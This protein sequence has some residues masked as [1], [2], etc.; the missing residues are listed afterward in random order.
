M[1]ISKYI[2][3]F[4][5]AGSMLGVSTSCEDMLDKGNEFVVYSD[6]AYLRNPAD[7]VTSLLGILGKLQGIAERTNLLGEVRADLVVVNENA[8]IDLKNLA[9]NN[10]DINSDEET[11]LYNDPRDYYA[12]I[13]N[14][15]FYLSHVDSLAHNISNK[16]Y[17]ENEIAQV[18]SIRA[19]TYLQA[20]LVYGKVPFVTEPVTTK[21]QS[22]AEYP[23]YDLAAICEY[24]IN[25]LKNLANVSYPDFNN[26]GT[27]SIDPKAMFYPVNVVLGDLYLYMAV[28]THDKEAAKQAALSYY[29]YITWRY[30]GKTNLYTSNARSYWPGSKW[31]DIKRFNNPTQSTAPYYIPQRGRWGSNGVTQIT[32]IAMD[33]AAAEGHFNH[34]RQLYNTT[35]DTEFSEA[36]ISPS[37]ILKELSESQEYVVRLSDLGVTKLTRDM[38]DDSSLESNYFGDLRY[39]TAMTAMKTNMNNEIKSIQFIYKHTSQHIS[40]YRAHQIYLRMAEALNYA[41]YPRMAREILT[42]GLN[43]QVIEFFVLPYYTNEADKNFIKQFDFPNDEFRTVVQTFEW[44]SRDPYYVDLYP[45]ITL[46]RSTDINTLGLHSRGSGDT[47]VN[48]NYCVLSLTD[49]EEASRPKVEDIGKMPTLSDYTWPEEPVRPEEAVKPSTWDVKPGVSVTEAEYKEINTGKPWYKGKATILN[50]FYRDYVKNDSVGSY[51]RALE[52]MAQYEIDIVNYEKEYQ[53]VMAQF[54]ADLNAYQD[55]VDAYKNTLGSWKETTYGNPAHIEREMEVVDAAILN[56]QALE[57]VYEGNRFYDL[58]R[59]ALWYGDN[60]RLADPV[61]KRDAQAGARLR[62]RS[63]WYLHWKNGKSQIGY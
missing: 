47:Y 50:G 37:P 63:G 56:E 32:A 36:S 8:T 62:S 14:C 23:L 15:N 20:V 11:N 51:T 25:D 5:L 42:N 13:N 49:E 52:A 39:S 40:V 27:E 43:N 7:T 61:S 31:D 2:L 22:D 54:E 59:R 12:V 6:D 46:T 38:F 58:M 35:Y 33:S 21:I 3:S 53:I 4:A 29:R 34:L 44:A 55:R 1:K 28:A 45:T 16:K 9:A 26:V 17:F 57:L 48:E 19:W 24:F 18:R 10:A 30:S 60:N 41:G